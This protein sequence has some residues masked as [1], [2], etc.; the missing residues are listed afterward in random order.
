MLLK[1][2]RL[3]PSVVSGVVQFQP[4]VGGCYF[5]PSSEALDLKSHSCRVQEEIR[6]PAGSTNELIGLS[7]S[8]LKRKQKQI[9]LEQNR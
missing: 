9:E 4:P 8:D 3:N 6:G 7:A 1:H 2:L 5:I